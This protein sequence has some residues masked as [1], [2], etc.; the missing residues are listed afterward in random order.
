MLLYI[1]FWIFNGLYYTLLY[2]FWTNLL[3][4]GP[5]HIAVFLPISVFRRKGISNGVQTEWNLRESYFWNRIF[6]EDLEYTRGNEGGGHEG[7]GRPQWGRRASH[8]RGPPLAPPVPSFLLYISMY[9]ENIEAT[10]KILIPPPQ[11]F[12]P[13]RSH[14]GAC[15]GAPP[16]GGSTTECFYINTIASTM[17]CE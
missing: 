17:S 12:V 5:V 6:T 11:P 13:M 1:L 15:S 2:Y 9:P 14:L 8:P 10:E 7:P 3:T 16:E 4:Q